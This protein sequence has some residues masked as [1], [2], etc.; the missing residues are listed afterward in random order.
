MSLKQPAAILTAVLVAGV[1]AADPL[2]TG[3]YA[4]PGGVPAEV[5]MEA[6]R[7]MLSPAPGVAPVEIEVVSQSGDCYQLQYAQLGLS[8]GQ[9][10]LDMLQTTGT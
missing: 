7:L 6:N 2:P 3:T 9:V 5:T 1:A 8:A 4:L 10:C